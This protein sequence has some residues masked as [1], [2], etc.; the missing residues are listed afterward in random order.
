ME[1]KEINRLLIIIVVAI[2][3]L[4]FSRTVNVS[5]QEDIANG[6]LLDPF[7]ITARIDVNGSTYMGIDA[8]VLNTGSEALRSAEI[9]IDSLNA[10]ILSASVDGNVVNS[11]LTAMERHTM[12]SL[13]LT[14]ELEIN[15]SVWIHLELRADD[16]QSRLEQDSIADFSHGSMTYYVRPHVP[17]SNFTF[18]AILPGHASLSHDSV[19][20]LFPQ[21]KDNFTDGVAMVF[22]WYNPSLLPGQEDVFIVRYQIPTTS[23]VSNPTSLLLL[24]IVGVFGILLGL[25]GAISAPRLRTLLRRLGAVQYAGITAEESM[26]IESI[27]MKG[28]SCSQKELYRQLD[29]SES[30]LSLVLG[31]LEEKGIISRVRKGRENIV[32]I[33]EW[34]S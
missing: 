21:S 4:G 11:S 31:G 10:A 9:R 7:V 16:L 33:M 20:P 17:I 19:V 15:K 28:G 13:S 23:V 27:Q 14:Q 30:K 26:I 18:I 1:V 32:H 5:A 25:G 6:I 24:S 12:V 34:A 2:L 29:I 8:R 3:V 22:V